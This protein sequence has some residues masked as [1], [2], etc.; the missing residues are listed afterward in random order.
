MAKNKTTFTDVHVTE[1]VN[2]FVDKEEKKSDAF[3]LIELLQEWSGESPKMYGPSIIAFGNYKYKYASG[4]EGEAPVLAFSPRKTA[5]T[6]Y[7]FSDTEKS[8]DI[9]PQLGKFKK[10]KGCIY[11]KKL[12]DIDISILEQLCIESI[13]Y[14]SEHHE[15]SCHAK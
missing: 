13:K 10:T 3:R 1:F 7:V 6:L 4:H 14:I 11:V 5:L 9:L 8:N 2:S 15:C 12:E